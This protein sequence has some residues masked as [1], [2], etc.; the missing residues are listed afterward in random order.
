MQAESFAQGIGVIQNDEAQ[1]MSYP[2]ISATE[3]IR[4][5]AELK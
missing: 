5:A 1:G 3:A 4:P 2:A